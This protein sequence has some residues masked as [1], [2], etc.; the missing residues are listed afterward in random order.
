MNDQRFAMAFSNRLSSDIVLLLTV[1]TLSACR[2]PRRDVHDADLRYVVTT[3][4]VDIGV[5]SG[6]FC[7]AVDPDDPKGLWWWEPGNDCS[8]RSTG[9][10]VF[11]AEEAMVLP[12]VRPESR[13]I[14]FRLPVIR[15]P[16]SSEPSFIDVALE[17]ERGQ[18]QSVITGSR[19]ATVARQNLDI[20]QVWQTAR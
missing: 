19:T 13:D 4:P 8:S 9:P 14:R 20:P 5:G 11:Q 1:L 17:L 12:G 15:A 3:N 10:G 18:L 16:N 6:R 7:F 2:E